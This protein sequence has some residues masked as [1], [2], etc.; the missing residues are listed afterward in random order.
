[1]KLSIIIVSWNTRDLLAGCLESVFAN[2]PDA[3]FEVWVVDNASADDSVAMVRRQFP[4]VRLLENATNVG[5]AQANNLAVS[6]CQGEYVLLL[7]PDTVVQPGA[8][9]ALV[10]FMDRHSDAGAAGSMLLNPDGSL[11]VSCHPAPT[12][13]RELWRLFHLDRMWAYG[14]YPMHTWPVDMPRE[15]DVI[16]GASFIVRRQILDE[17]GLLDGDYF[18]YSE[19]VDLCYRLQKAGWRLYWVPQS[20]VIHFGGQST[21]QV[22]A[23]M[24]LQ[25]YLGKLKYFRKHYGRFAGVAYKGILLAA[26]LA[27]LMLTPLAWLQKP[28]AR[29]RNLLLARHYGRLL[30][31]LPTM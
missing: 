18:M 1:M 15:V 2:P 20:R 10:Q 29:E 26:T 30:I 16:Q 9:N 6:R 4:R 14:R 5:F 21:R 25:L 11:Q 24:F 13:K 7:N 23:E 3:P 17:I 28:P 8:L 22:A 19:E 31:T 12:L 27:R